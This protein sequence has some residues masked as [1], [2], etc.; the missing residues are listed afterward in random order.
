M[1]EGTIDLFILIINNLLRKNSIMDLA[2]QK[3]MSHDLK[4]HFISEGTISPQDLYDYTVFD[5]LII[6]E[7]LGTRYLIISYFKVDN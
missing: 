2:M 5:T 3:R 1:G 6:S 4:I 7:I